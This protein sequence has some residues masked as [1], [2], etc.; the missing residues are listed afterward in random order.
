MFRDR[1]H[2]SACPQATKRVVSLIG[3]VTILFV[4][5]IIP[6]VFAHWYAKDATVR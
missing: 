6:S 5:M 4:F 1:F 3:H 2:P